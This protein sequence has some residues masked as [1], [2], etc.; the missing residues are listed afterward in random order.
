[1]RVLAGT[2]AHTLVYIVLLLDFTEYRSISFFSFPFL[3]F[4]VDFCTIWH[5]FQEHFL[6]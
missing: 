1:M 2:T 3:F 4:S 6:R 5:I